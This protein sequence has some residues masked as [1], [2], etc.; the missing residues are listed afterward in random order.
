MNSANIT[1][2]NIVKDCRQY[3]AHTKNVAMSGS[4]GGVMASKKRLGDSESRQ[5]I[6]NAAS[7]RIPGPNGKRV[8]RESVQRPVRAQPMRGPSSEIP[9]TAY[10]KVGWKD[11]AMAGGGIASQ[12]EL[13]AKMKEDICTQL[14]IDGYVQSFVDL[15]YLTHRNDPAAQQ[16]ANE[17]APESQ[18]P[19]FNGASD[20]TAKSSD[21]TMLELPEMGF[22]RDQLVAAEHCKRRGEIPDVMAAYD[23]L[24]TYCSEKQD[25]KTMIFFY[26][27]CLEIS[28][29]VK[30]QISE[31]RVLNQ[32]GG[33][34]HAAGDLEQ[35]R[36]YLELCVDIAKVVYEHEDDEELR[37]EAYSQLG[38]VYVDLALRH[39]RAKQFL[40]AIQL[41]KL[42]LDCAIKSNNFEAQA[43][44]QFKIGTC[45]NAL[46]EPS[47]ALPFLETN[48]R[49]SQESSTLSILDT[50][51]HLSIEFLNNY[52]TI[53]TRAENVVN[54]ADACARL[55]QIYT[56]AQN[57]HRAREMHEKNYELVQAVASRTGDRLAQNIS[58]VSVGAARANDKLGT[59]LTLVKEDFHGLLAWKNTRAVPTTERPSSSW[60]FISLAASSA[61]SNVEYTRDAHKCEVEWSGVTSLA[62]SSVPKPANTSRSRVS[63]VFQCKP[64]VGKTRKRQA[65][66]QH[67]YTRFPAENLGP[68]DHGDVRRHHATAGG[69]HGRPLAALAQRPQRHHPG[70]T[71]GHADQFLTTGWG[72]TLLL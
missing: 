63:S 47:N 57:F 19:N 25:T 43:N 18:Q 60:P 70:A 64:A 52:V 10:A 6:E 56:A 32:I 45:Y 22:L 58:R 46:D 33:G 66:L 17:S 29:L 69:S 61:S 38:K 14:L 71:H 53:A 34:Y 24:A 37:G 1:R 39:E 3:I 7:S 20:A 8:V 16:R 35:A 68:T 62:S 36:Q 5:K 65:R 54:Q 9:G 23:S 11:T 15:F 30:D 21:F 27:K 41:Y 31:M 51:F 72:D 4:A 42:R 44:A 50:F 67:G 13:Q 49:C 2:G 48:V 55:G 26:E 28:R 59:L 12:A 40:E